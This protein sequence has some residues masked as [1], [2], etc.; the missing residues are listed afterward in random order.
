MADNDGGIDISALL[1]DAPSIP[2]QEPA[3]GTKAPEPKAGEVIPPSGAKE[4]P[5]KAQDTKPD[6][7]GQAPE[8]GKEGTPAPTPPP[9]APPPDMT[10]RLLASQE[11]IARALEA[12]G[13]KSGQ[14]AGEGKPKAPKF[15]IAVP[16]DIITSMASDDPK[17]RGTAVSVLANGLMNTVYNAVVESLE[18]KFASVPQLIQRHLDSHQSAQS[19]RND[20]YSKFPSHD[21][22]ALH[23]VVTNVAARLVKESPGKG[24][25]PELRDKVGAE[26]QRII[27]AAVGGEPPPADA[28]KSKPAPKDPPFSTKGSN[29]GGA[30][31]PNAFL[32]SVGATS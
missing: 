31:K 24:W 28:G 27:M 20:Y 6:G 16:A 29:R 12:S 32:D 14:P 21:N 8:P 17:E 18:Q 26:V 10:E 15:N 1:G 2:S 30:E 4:E 11:A 22:P 9:A 25:S 3:P 13:Q 5:P 19:I 7:G 23:A